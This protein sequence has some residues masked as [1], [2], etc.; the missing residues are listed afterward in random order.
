MDVYSTHAKLAEQSKSFHYT[1][2]EAIAVSSVRFLLPT[3]YSMAAL[4][5]GIA[6]DVYGGAH[7]EQETLK[8][9]NLYTLKLNA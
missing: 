5:G 4:A 1:D 7:D 3:V 8:E 2:S 6:Y 9:T